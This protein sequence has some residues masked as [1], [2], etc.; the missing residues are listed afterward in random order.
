MSKCAQ[1]GAP[2]A[3]YYEAYDAHLCDENYKECFLSDNPKFRSR[4]E[5]A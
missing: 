1:C 4:E 5:A 3:P 2:D